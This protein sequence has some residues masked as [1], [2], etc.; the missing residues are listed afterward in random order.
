MQYFDEM[1]SKY[2]FGDGAAVPEDAML[3]RAVYVGALNVLAKK[4]GSEVRAIAFD[5]QG[6]NWCLILFASVAEADKIPEFAI[7]DGT[8]KGGWTEMEPD[9]AMMNAISIAHADYDLDRYVSVTARIHPH[10][11]RFLARLER[12]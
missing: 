5:R 9:E 11:D 6:H 2:G 4:F 12:S 1:R 8:D 3:R 10:F 7:R